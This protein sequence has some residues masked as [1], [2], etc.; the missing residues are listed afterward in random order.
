M[1]K[2]IIVLLITLVCACK[3][4]QII[5][6]QSR[7]ELP[8][9]YPLNS[10]VD[11][12]N[13]IIDWR[14]YFNDLN[15]AAL[16]DTALQNNQDIKI[17]LQHL[18]MAKAG[19]LATSSALKPTINFTSSLSLRKFGLYTMDGAGNITT[20]ITPNN[21]VPIHLPDFMIG[22][23]ASWELDLYKKLSNKN[24]A[25][26]TRVLATQEIKS[27]IITNLIH[28]IATAY[29]ELV[30]LD[31]ELKIIDEYI[32]L[33][34]DAVNL[35]RIQ[36]DAASAN[37]LAVKQ[38]EAQLYNLQEMK[39]PILQSI[40]EQENKINFLLGR[41][42]RP[43]KRVTPP[44]DTI[45]LP[46]FSFGIPTNLLLNRPDL[47][48]TELELR[49]NKFDLQAARAAFLP[50]FNIN[51]MLGTQAFRPDFLFSKPQSLAYGLLGGFMIPWINKRSIQADFDFAKAKHQVTLFTYNKQII[52]AYTE[53][54]NQLILQ[55]NLE[56][57]Y[58]LKIK[59][60][61]L[62]SESINISD[63]LYRNNR[64]TYLEVLE[65]QKNAIEA[66]LSL[67][68]IKKTQLQ[69]SVNIYKALGGGWQ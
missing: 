9:N 25:A 2:Y 63:K 14:I 55:L 43:I 29:Y 42:P 41:F 3:A 16:I 10:R 5:H 28:Q 52:E 64:A 32:K 4:P 53:V 68:R 13:R 50:S 38:F 35:I 37:E 48:Q 34:E 26:L 24:K 45:T 33:Q 54:Y 39:Y 44:V 56:R 51:A 19:A 21:I 1:K 31:S 22:F 36:K 17:T 18:E 57:S 12:S 69:S 60:N 15:L 6:N 7:I 11:S 47:R 40:I 23:Q 8:S 20:E 58:Q 66:K 67:V 46:S 27:L 62:L 65:V 59:E 61:N 49:A 30:G